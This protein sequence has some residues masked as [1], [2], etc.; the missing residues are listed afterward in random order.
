[1]RLVPFRVMRV[2][3]RRGAEFLSRTDLYLDVAVWNVLD[4]LGEEF[5][6]TASDS[7]LLGHD[8]TG[9]VGDGET[10]DTEFVLV[11]FEVVVLSVEFDEEAVWEYGHG[12]EDVEDYFAD[13]GADD[14]EVGDVGGVGEVE[15]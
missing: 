4:Y 9:G 3:L 5:R 8:N 7:S 2:V 15:F 6:N 13:G 10:Q 11:G 14:A 12:G 1:M